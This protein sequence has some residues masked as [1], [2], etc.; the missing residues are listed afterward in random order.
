M[1]PRGGNYYL[2]HNQGT[3]RAEAYRTESKLR[4]ERRWVFVQEVKKPLKL[5]SKGADTN[6]SRLRRQSSSR[7]LGRHPRGVSHRLIPFSHLPG[8]RLLL[9]AGYGAGETL[10]LREKSIS[11]ISRGI[12]ALQ[13]DALQN[14]R[15]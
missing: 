12:Q 13:E 5:L 9:Q 3:E 6:P 14:W 8:V 2:S 7:Q 1:L 11:A 4:N 15:K 10:G